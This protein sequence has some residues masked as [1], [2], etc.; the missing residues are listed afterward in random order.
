MPRGAGGGEFLIRQPQ[1]S[2][3][4]TGNVFRVP[5]AAKLVKG[6]SN[7]DHARVVPSNDLAPLAAATKVLLK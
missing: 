3:D 6:F 5:G 1:A 7:L 4:M 2:S